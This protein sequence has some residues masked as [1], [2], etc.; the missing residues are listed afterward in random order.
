MDVVA[1]KRSVVTQ[2]LKETR[3]KLE[4]MLSQSRENRKG[5]DVSAF[6]TGDDDPQRYDAA[7]VFSSTTHRIKKI[8]AEIQA[9]SSVKLEHTND[10]IGDGSLLEMTNQFGE[11]RWF[12]LLP[13]LGGGDFVPDGLTEEVTVITAQSPLAQSLQ[14]TPKGTPFQV[15]QATYTLVKSY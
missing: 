3:D 1:I 7:A 8:Q 12:L 14:S 11:P 10:N 4:R 5:L 13:A 9:V 2:L 6:H 15:N